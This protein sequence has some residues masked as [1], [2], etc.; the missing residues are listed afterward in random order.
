MATN[1]L[2]KLEFA[3]YRVILALNSQGELPDHED[4]RRALRKAFPDITECYAHETLSRTTRK[5]V[6]KRII[7]KRVVSSESKTKTG[8]KVP[9]AFEGEHGDFEDQTSLGD[10][11]E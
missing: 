4:V 11:Q 7:E 8:F 6:G 1:K 3:I 2:S 10:F 9:I 5:M